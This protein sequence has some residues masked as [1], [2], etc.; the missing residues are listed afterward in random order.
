MAIK[1]NPEQLAMLKS[2]MDEANQKSHFIIFESTELDSGDNL[3]LITD[4]DSFKEI[5]KAHVDQAK[6]HILQDIVP[7]TDNLAK[8]AIAESKAANQNDDPETLADL[9][10]YTNAVLKENRIKLNQES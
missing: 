6:M 1:T 3:R 4:Y 2:Q 8:W 9:E 10:H 5:R 7:I